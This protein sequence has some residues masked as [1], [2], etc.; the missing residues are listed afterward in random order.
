[1][2]RFLCT[3]FNYSLISLFL[4]EHADKS[5]SGIQHPSTSFVPGVFMFKINKTKVGD[6]N[7]LKGIQK[8]TGVVRT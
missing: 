4:Y 5:S 3:G 7:R 8:L 6:K 1:M 2:I